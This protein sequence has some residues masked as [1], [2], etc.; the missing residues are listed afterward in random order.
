MEKIN[1]I[2]NF[3][4]DVGFAVSNERY[5]GYQGLVI[6]SN[7]LKSN[8]SMVPYPVEDDDVQTRLFQFSFNIEVDKDQFYHE[9]FSKKVLE[10][11]KNLP[12]GSFTIFDSELICY[13]YVM[14]CNKE[15]DIDKMILYD[16]MNV[17][18]YVMKLAASNLKQK[19]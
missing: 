1:Q 17:I 11:N 12:Y 19:K 8:V 2:E 15:N 3:L 10:M 6:S 13:K 7:E 4:T 18:T 14:I 9:S 16:I 5:A